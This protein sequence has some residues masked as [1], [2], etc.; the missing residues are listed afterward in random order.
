[1][2]EA[3]LALVELLDVAN[4]LARW[5]AI[6]GRDKL[7]PPEK[8][9][10]RLIEMALTDEDRFVREWAAATLGHYPEDRE[11]TPLLLSLLADPDWH[12]NSG[13]TGLRGMGD[14]A[15]L[16]PGETVLKRRHSAARDKS[17]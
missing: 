17:A 14:I 6:A 3:I 4:P 1:V 11:L 12:V 2:T 9:K 15:A 10:P 13:A 7:G 8:V 5:A 16:G